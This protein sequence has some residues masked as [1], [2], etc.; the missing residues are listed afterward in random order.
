MYLAYL[1]FLI[2]FALQL[3]WT[4]VIFLPKQNIF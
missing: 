2:S 1:D 3:E 4:Y